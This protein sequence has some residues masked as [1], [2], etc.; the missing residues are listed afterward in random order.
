MK[1]SKQPH[2]S[3]III[4]PQENSS[5][6]EQ[7]ILTA[8]EIEFSERGLD[9]ARMQA[10]ADRA[11]VNKALLHYYFRS[12]DKLFDVILE[13]AV[14]SI[15]EKINTELATSSP[16]T[17]FKTAIHALVSA[18]IQ[19]FSKQ[20]HIPRILVR[21]LLNSDYKFK[22]IVQT[23]LSAIGN[24]PN[25]LYA[26]YQKDVTLGKVKAADPLQLIMNIMGMILVTF[27]SQPISGFIQQKTGFSILYDDTFYR[28]RTEFI[29]DMICNGIVTK[30]SQS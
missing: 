7:K 22:S 1:K 17:D 11:G 21:Q 4:G 6:T 3:T 18:Y 28:N 24:G 29:T 16:A 15:W 2:S 30:D 23:V 19:T 8:A 12:K 20:P 13:K 26:I 14:T 27:I 5:A 10:I 25:K 9:G